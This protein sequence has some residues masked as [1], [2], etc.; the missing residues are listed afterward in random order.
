MNKNRAKNRYNQLRERP[1]YKMMRRIQAKRAWA[2][3]QEDIEGTVKNQCKKSQ[4]QAV[5]PHCIKS[6]TGRQ[7]L[8]AQ[9]KYWIRRSRLLAVAVERRRML[10][11]QQ[12][13]A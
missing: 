11:K 3:R 10:A 7:A 5:L 9:Q 13:N 4:T 2:S 8:T 12:K 1:S 6:T